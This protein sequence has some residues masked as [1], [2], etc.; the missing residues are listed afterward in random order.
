MSAARAEVA[1]QAAEA[2]AGR[3]YAHGDHPVR[4]LEAVAAAEAN[5]LLDGDPPPDAAPAADDALGRV[6][7]RIARRALAARRPAGIDG[8][9]AYHDAGESPA[10]ARAERPVARVGEMLFYAPGMAPPETAMDR[11]T[12]SLQS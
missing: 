6:C 4:T 9:T 11:E 3:L 5:R 2:I 7:R 10:W 8:A 1:V 12:G